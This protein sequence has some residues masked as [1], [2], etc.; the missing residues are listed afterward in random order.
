[1]VVEIDI[2][3]VAAEVKGMAEA[4]GELGA[5]AVGVLYREEEKV[6]GVARYTEEA[7]ENGAAKG[8][9]EMSSGKLEAA[10]NGEGEVENSDV[11]AAETG[12]SAEESNGGQEA[13]EAESEAEAGEAASGRS[14]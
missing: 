13:A 11:A 14:R 7:E 9:E 3:K 12:R 5:A 6:V 1:M 4:Y 10:E 2:G 8:A